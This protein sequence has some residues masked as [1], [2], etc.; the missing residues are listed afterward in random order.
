MDCLIL[1]YGMRLAL[2]SILISGAALISQAS[3]QNPPDPG[4]ASPTTIATDRPAVTDS[5][6]VVPKGLFQVENGLLD[7]LNQGRRTLDFPEALVRMGM[8]S[9]TE[10]RLTAPDYYNTELT[11]AGPRSGFGDLTIGIKQQLSTVGGFQLAAVISLSLPTG[12][13]AISS[14]GYDPS[15]QLPWSRKLSAD[16]TVAGM[17]SIYVPTQNGSHSVVGESTFLIDPR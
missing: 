5:S 10:L 4:T 7:T 1:L 12:A 17:L 2:C 13:Y 8:R 16:W 11:A 15:F 14:H 3:A 9:N 6:A